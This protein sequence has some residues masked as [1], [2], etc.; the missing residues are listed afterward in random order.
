MFQNWYCKKFIQ[1]PIGK[2]NDMIIMVIANHIFSLLKKVARSFQN[3]ISNENL[4]GYLFILVDYGNYLFCI[5]R[6][7]LFQIVRTDKSKLLNKTLQLN[8]T[9]KC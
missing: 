7:K 3:L 8:K 5:A 2:E 6:G 9:L 4:F 1:P